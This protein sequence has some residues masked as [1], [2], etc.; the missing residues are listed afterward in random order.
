MAMQ[1]ISSS[2]NPRFR[3]AIELHRSR[4][5]KKQ[6]RIIIFGARE[7]GRSLAAGVEPIELFFDESVPINKEAALAKIAECSGIDAAIVQTRATRAMFCELA[8]ELFQSL[9]FG[10][11]SD[12]VVMTARRP[13]ANL[14]RLESLASQN[15]PGPIIVCQ[16][17]E[18]PGNLGGILRTA[19][20]SGAAAVIV[21]DAKTDPFHPNAIRNSAGTCFSIPL[22]VCETQEA[23]EWLTQHQFDVCVATP[24]ASN[25]HDQLDLTRRCAIVLGNEASGVSTPWR[26]KSNEQFHLPM[27]GIAD[28]LN[29]SVTGAILMY[30]SLRQR[31]NRQEK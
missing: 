27:L 28:S 26:E 16:S 18:N 20:A 31:R 11:R 19:D 8:P 14:D 15:S 2:S 24:E 7:I 4:G 29:V 5:R 6:R 30:E 17:L 9:A 21:A 12:G 25:R 10:D 1:K 13:M 22:A 3:S 23:I